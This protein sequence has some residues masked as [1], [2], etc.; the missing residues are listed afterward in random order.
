MDRLKLDHAT[1]RFGVFGDP[2]AHSKSPV[3]MNSAFEATGINAIY[4]AFHVK[5]EQLRSAVEGIRGLG[6]RGVNV[7]IPHKQAVMD[8]LDEIDEG[9]RVIGA[10]NTIV[11]NNGVL[12][13]YNTDGIGYVRSLKEETGVNLAGK[14]ILLIGAGG[15]AR[16]VAYALANEVPEC[17]WIINRTAERAVEL[18]RS[19]QAYADVRGMGTEGLDD[20]KHKVDIVINT[21]SIG[22][23]PDVDGR[24]ADPAAFPAGTLFSDLIYN[25][26]VT[27]WLKEAEEHGSIVHGGLGMFIYQGAYAFEYWT[28]RQAPVQ[29]MREAVE[30]ALQQS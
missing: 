29:V 7:T 10:V 6:L 5:P 19:L 24:P 26:R 1:M 11:N 8:Y 9:A 17:I 20:I 27:R 18:A 3:M 30:R 22:M 12:V 2:I 13:G 14:R 28:G 23:L 15:A 4:M 16:G 21:T 25:P